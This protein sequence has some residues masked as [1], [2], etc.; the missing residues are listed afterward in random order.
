MK[1]FSEE[2]IFMAKTTFSEEYYYFVNGST[3]VMKYYSLVNI[4]LA[5][6]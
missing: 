5:T 4:L 6:K 1:C 3:L 2:I